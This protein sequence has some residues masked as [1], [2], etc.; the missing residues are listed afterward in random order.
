M[1][2]DRLISILSLLQVHRRLTSSELAGRLEVSERTIHRD[3]EALSGMGV[4]VYAQRGVGGGWVLEEAYR[5]DL[6]GLNED[7]IRTLFLAQ[8]AHLLTDLGLKGASQGALAKLLAALPSGRRRDAEF[9]RRRIYVDTAGWE[10][11]KEAVPALSTLQ[12]ALWQARQ[13]RLIYKRGDGET[14]ERVVDPLGLVL[15]GNVWYLV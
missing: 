7:E 15:K 1:R 13:I 9:M 5:T 6:T 8:P 10:A 12:D 4:P 14:V 11:R 2:A 3:M